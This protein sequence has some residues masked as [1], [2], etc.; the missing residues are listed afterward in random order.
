MTT[1]IAEANI[2]QETL[3]NL[4]SGP[5]IANVQIANSSYTILDDTAVSLDGGYIIINGSKFEE[6]VNVLI[7][8][9]PATSV[10]YVS[11]TQVRAQIP[12]ATAGSKHVYVV[13]TDTG[14]TAIRVNGLTYSGVPSWNTDSSLGEGILDEPIIISLSA[15]ADS[16][17][18]YQLQT[19]SSLPTGLSLAANGLLSGTVTGLEEE[20]LYNFTIEAIDEEN[21]E[22]PR[23]FSVTIILGDEY[24]NQ[25]VLLLKGDGTNGAQNNTFLDSSTNNFTITRNDN[26]TQGT[27]SPF[28]VA[29][30]QWS[31][32]FDGT[33]DFVNIGTNYPAALDLGSSNFTIEGFV[34]LQAATKQLLVGNLNDSNGTCTFFVM[35]NNTTASARYEVKLGGT[36]YNLGTGTVPTNQWVHVCLIR[37]GTNVYLFENGEQVGD[38]QPFSGSITSVSNQLR[39]GGASTGQYDLNGYVSNIRAVIGSVVYSILGFSPPTS[40]LTAI[41]NTSLLTCQSNGFVDNSS[42]AI[43]ITPVNTPKVTPFSPFAPTAAYSPSVNGGSGYFDGS[44]DYLSS[45][46][47]G[48][49]GSGEF[50]IRAWVYPTALSSAYNHVFDTRPN[51][52]V[53][54]FSWGVESD[55]QIF[56]YSVNAFRIQNA[57]AAGVVPLN[58]WSHICVTRDSSNNLKAFVNGVQVGS[59]VSGWTAN[60][61][62]T[63]TLISKYWGGTSHWTGYIADAQ[64]IAGVEDSSVPTSP[65]TNVSGTTLLL[66]FTNAG[67]FDNTGKNVLETVGNAQIDTTTK[68]FGTGAMKFDG[69]GD[70]IRIPWSQDLWFANGDWTVEMWIYRTRTDQYSVIFEN[71]YESVTTRSINIYADNASNGLLRIAQSENG[72]TNFDT[73]LGVNVPLNEWAH[74]AVVRQGSTVKGYVNGINSGTSVAAKS[75]YRITTN[76]FFVGVQGDLQTVTY[77]IGYIDDLRITKGLA[78][79]ITLPTK[80]FPVR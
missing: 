11:E 45:A 14:A 9:V 70:Y 42:N 36:A 75:L 23:A 67:I 76:D 68:Q 54:G 51:S 1:K 69:T 52:D 43:A 26:T 78:R 19:G 5:L 74:I 27:F 56:F 12:A 13:N 77:F 22:S 24:F 8:N 7:N 79:T 48:S 31:N 58:A 21:Q 71:G 20:T 17:V 32:Y 55:G 47:G 3:D 33:D 73:S 18:S 65:S 15:T 66:N 59:T 80:A 50:T 60:Y 4:G 38:T 28:S 25:T 46:G 72:S 53:T 10:V 6:N 63:T 61:T 41:A 62:Q 64:M 2:K 44:G 16:N 40:S 57:G 49:I 39:V 35:L 29:E 34:Y 30:G 37:S